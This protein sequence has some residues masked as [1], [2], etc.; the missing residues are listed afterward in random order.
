MEL[1]DPLRSYAVLIGSS[2]YADPGLDDL[3][4]VANN[5]ARLGELLEDPTVWGLPPDRCVRVPEPASPAEVLDAVHD[6][7]RRTKDTLLVYY[8]GH[9]LSDADGLLLT[10]PSTDPQRPYTSVGF[11]SVRREVLTAPRDANRIVILDCCYSG[12]ALLGGMSGGGAANAPV[13]MAEQTRIAGSYLLTASAA[14]RKALAPPGE[15]YTAFTGELIR[16]L[17]QGLPGGGSLIEVTSVYERLRGE[18]LAKRRPL[19]QQRLSNTGRTLAIARNRYGAGRTA[20][21]PSETLPGPKPAPPAATIPDD[22]KEAL[23]GKPRAIAREYLR[24]WPT[25]G[26]RAHARELLHLAG[27]LRPPQEVAALVALLNG[28]SWGILFQEVAARGPQAVVE[29]LEALYAVDGAEEAPHGLIEVVTTQIPEAVVGTVRA[30]RAAGYPA[31][32]DRLLSRTV[33]ENAYTEYVLGLLGALWSAELDADADRVLAE[34]TTESDEEAVRFADALL[35]MG[36]RQKAFE[37][38]VR[39]AAVVVRRSPGELIRVV[40]ALD[41]EREEER[42][43]DQPPETADARIVLLQE[44]ASTLLDTAVAEA[45]APAG[46]AELCE[47]L[48][49]AGMEGRA[50]IALATAAES[51]DAPAVV[52]LADALRESGHA[53]GVRHLMR[54]AAFTHPVETTPYFVE[55]LRDMGWPVDANR[56]LATALTRSPEEIAALL[57]S[58]GPG[59]ERDRAQLVTAVNSRPVADRLRLLRVLLAGPGDHDDF[60]ASVALLPDGDFLEVLEALRAADDAS[61]LVTLFRFQIRADPMGAAGRLLFLIDNAEAFGVERAVLAA[62]AAKGQDGDSELSVAEVSRLVGPTVALEARVYATAA[63]WAA[64]CG[65]QVRTALFRQH[66]VATGTYLV[67]WLVALHAHSL[68]E[69]VNAVIASRSLTESGPPILADLVAGLAEADMKDAATFALGQYAFTLGP[70]QVSALARR[71][72]LMPVLPDPS[73]R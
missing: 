71:L 15:T 51:Y 2:A 34:A 23:R 11:D 70:K 1:A 33:S 55:A 32:A 60:L 8:A 69:C 48:W 56:L 36:R 63:L 61:V 24:L 35:T 6:A 65:E 52:E 54:A 73:R 39:A 9:G 59:R 21:P 30:L 40:K 49:S 10:L 26:G 67:S 72:A 29:C 38:Y 42:T 12:S 13:E 17:D 57:A 22:L 44:F 45:E 20:A 68:P 3:P 19:P 18:L 62:L 53:D 16:L 27:A 41:E 4:A 58:L 50:L 28:D 46:L 5:L 66:Y 43:R 14:T 7:A 64:G 25:E 37:L 47:A 31:E